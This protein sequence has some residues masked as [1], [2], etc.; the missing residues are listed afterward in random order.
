[1]A[2]GKKRKG[3]T[4]YIFSLPSNLSRP[5][6]AHVDRVSTNSRFVQ[7]K[8]VTFYA[9]RSLAKRCRV[10]E[11]T[12]DKPIQNSEAEEDHVFCH[13]LGDIDP[14]IFDTNR[15]KKRE[16]GFATAVCSVLFFLL[17]L[18]HLTAI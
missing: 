18:H 16:Q 1:M 4:G 5:S 12:Q 14:S 11:N 3:N 8:N 6:I 17:K 9:P 7:R 2:G 13:N 10:E 15:K